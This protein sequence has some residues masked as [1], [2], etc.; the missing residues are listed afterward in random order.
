MR[1]CP[2]CGYGEGWTKEQSYAK[3]PKYRVECAVCGATGPEAR[4]YD[5]AVKKWDGLLKNIQNE[6]KFKEAL[7]ESFHNDDHKMIYLKSVWEKQMDN[8]DNDYIP[9]ME[10]VDEYGEYYIKDIDEDAMGGVS[11]PMATLNNTPGVGNATPAAQADGNAVG[12]GDKWGD[13]M[14]Y[15]Q[16]GKVKTVKKKKKKKVIESNINPYDKIADMMAKKMGVKKPFK[17]KDSRTNTVEQEKFEEA[18]EP[19]FEI[20]SY[21][22]YRK[23]LSKLHEEELRDSNAG[24]D[25]KGKEEM[26]SLGIAYEFKP[27]QSGKNRVFIKEPMK[28]VLAKLKQGGWEKNNSNDQNTLWL[29]IKDDKEMRIWADGKNLPRVTVTP[30]KEEDV[31]ESV[32]IKKVVS[33]SFNPYLKS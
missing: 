6:D 26:E 8:P 27:A 2:F 15:D 25:I 1:A 32:K 20:P 19:S 31:E 3:S 29:F 16:N 11:A 7:N 13:D 22:D 33:N 23:N 14:M 10:W 4:S 18:E 5:M 30:K 28:D 17:K 12:S 24:K 21:E 9:F